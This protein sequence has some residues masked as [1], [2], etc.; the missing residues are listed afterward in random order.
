MHKSWAKVKELRP[1]LNPSFLCFID[2]PTPSPFQV[3]NFTQTLTSYTFYLTLAQDSQHKTQ[4]G[5][6]EPITPPSHPTPIC[7]LP[8]CL[9]CPATATCYRKPSLPLLGLSMWAS[10][11][12]PLLPSGSAA[13]LGSGFSA[14][15]L[16]SAPASKPP[17]R[18]TPLLPCPAPGLQPLF[19]WCV[20]RPAKLDG[21]QVRETS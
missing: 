12:G 7:G 16:P 3:A 21:Q 20:Y 2:T 13:Y 8:G 14:L 5:Q 11:L 6:H 18:R 4:A 10:Y 9:G 19:V 15:C 17:P 1:A